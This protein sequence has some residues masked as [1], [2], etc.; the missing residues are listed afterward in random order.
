[1]DIGEDERF[2]RA[3][4]LFNEREFEA[5]AELFEE[6]FA[7]AVLGET[8]LA[9]ALMQLAT[10][11]HHVE[12]G[13]RVAALERIAEGLVA[14]A[15]VDDARGIDRA[16]RVDRAGR[17]IAWIRDDRSRPPMPWPKLRRA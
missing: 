8:E 14:L 3:I 9:R 11:A 5:S 15:N 17:F 1:V 10:G 6:L 7:E 4:E 13:Q 12:R 16:A 2:G